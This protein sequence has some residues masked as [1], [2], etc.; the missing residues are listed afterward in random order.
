MKN[1]AL[2]IRCL[3]AARIPTGILRFDGNLHKI[4]SDP[5]RSGR[6]IKSPG[7][8]RTTAVQLKLAS[9]RNFLLNKISKSALVHFLLTFE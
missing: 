3:I 8:M 2:G 4:R 5:S 6:R 9:V 1:P 7:S